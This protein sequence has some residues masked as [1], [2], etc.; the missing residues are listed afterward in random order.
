MALIDDA[1]F[2]GSR[3]DA[4]DIDGEEAAHLL[5]V[6]SNG[7]LTLVGARSAIANWQGTRA[8]LE[9][10]HADTIDLLRA[11]QNGRP[12]PE[13]IRKRGGGLW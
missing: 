6:A 8:R 10:L 12:I 1:E 5:A 13:H 11:A 7:G 4:G 3:V 9:R 2:Y